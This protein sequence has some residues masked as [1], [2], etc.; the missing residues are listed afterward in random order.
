MAKKELVKKAAIVARGFALLRSS[1]VEGWSRV[2]WEVKGFPDHHD[3]K[4]FLYQIPQ[5][6]D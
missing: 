6:L 4:L 2:V 3:L 1:G 5:C